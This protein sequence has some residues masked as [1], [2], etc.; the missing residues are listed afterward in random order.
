MNLV[1][2]VSTENL[3]KNIYISFSAK[4]GFHPMDPIPKDIKGTTCTMAYP[5]PLLK[6]FFKC[7]GIYNI[8][9]KGSN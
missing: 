2:W 3:Q 5:T 1:R 6:L 9:L 8:H 4:W 7:F